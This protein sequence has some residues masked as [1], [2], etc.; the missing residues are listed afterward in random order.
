MEGLLHLCMPVV[1]KNTQSLM[2]VILQSSIYKMHIFP[3][4]LHLFQILQ[5]NLRMIE[6]NLHGYL[7]AEYN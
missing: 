3:L 7:C 1:N 2:N 6:C 4:I 5:L